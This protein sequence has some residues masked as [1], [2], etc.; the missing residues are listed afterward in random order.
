MKINHRFNIKLSSF[1]VAL[2]LLLTATSLFIGLSF[3]SEGSLYG[4]DSYLHY[5]I[6]KYS[7]HRPANFLDHWGKPL[8]TLLSAPFAYFGFHG[9]MLFNVLICS[10]ASFMA[11]LI[12]RKL[13][14]KNLP[15]VVVFT[16]FAPIFILLMFSGLTEAVFSLLLITAVYFFMDKKY[17][18]T[19]ILISLI[20]FVRSEGVMFIAWFFILLLIKKQYKSL[21]FLLFGV[22]FYSILGGFILGDFFWLI[23]NNPYKASGGVYDPGSLFDYVT[24]VPATFGPIVFLLAIAGLLSI[25]ILYFIRRK[26]SVLDSEIQFNE[27]FVIA[28]SALGY[29]VFHS[30]ICWKGWMSVLGD[31]RFMA[32]IV[33]LVGIMALKGFNSLVLPLRNRWIIG[34]LIITVG[35]IVTHYGLNKHKLPVKFQGELLVVKQATIWIVENGYNQN[36]I[37]YY[38]PVIPEFLDKNPFD[39]SE[40]FTFVPD[41]NE[42]DKGVDKN[43]IVIW[44]G[45]FSALEGNVP[46]SRMENNSNYK[47]LK[48]FLP[49]PPFNIFGTMEYKV[50]VFI[51]K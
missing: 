17:V 41:F 51:R 44:D 31:P 37:I 28:F 21:P 40:F 19:A 30:V 13:G 25:V 2:I 32:A 5:L 39:N 46:F 27:L 9:M 16:I 23:S 1:S 24:N 22:L 15:L 11:L 20:P 45:H 50:G 47:L 8:F 43:T 26:K 14:Y 29:F 10:M 34:V 3:L 33:P 6:S 36:K 18:L 35:G 42:P 38:N 4:G 48:V 49:D 12:S 7:F